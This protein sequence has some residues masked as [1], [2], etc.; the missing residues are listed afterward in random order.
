MTTSMTL[1]EKQADIA[2]QHL[3]CSYLIRACREA[4]YELALDDAS[5]SDVHREAIRLL[6]VIHQDWSAARTAVVEH[7][8]RSGPRCA[9]IAGAS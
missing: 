2:A 1:P 9:P 5:E 8:A 6:K 3:V 7:A 4:M